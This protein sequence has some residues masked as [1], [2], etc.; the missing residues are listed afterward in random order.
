MNAEI[1]NSDLRRQ[2]YYAEAAA[3]ADDAQSRM[4]KSTR[5]AWKVAAGAAV[6]AVLQAIAI[7]T[8]MPLKEVRPYTILVDKTTGYIETAAGLKTGPLQ[9]DVAVTH[10]NLVQYV[11]ARETFDAA[12]LKENYRRVQLLSAGDAREQ[13]LKEMASTNPASPL[14]LYPASTVVQTTIKNVSLLNPTTALVRFD[15]TRRDGAGSIGGTVRPYSAVVTFR[16]TGAPMR[17]RDRF[18]NPLGFQVIRY[19]RDG[20]TAGSLAAPMRG[21]TEP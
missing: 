10:A 3:W 5:I 1:P 12:D 6:I 17:M 20:E 4:K 21:T 19:R 2:A 8:M 16:Y 9:Q 13:Y 7:A 11:L 18:E 14:K 15:A